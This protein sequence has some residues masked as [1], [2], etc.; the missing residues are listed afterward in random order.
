MWQS[1]PGE[2][3]E[4]SVD[5]T[6]GALTAPE[7]LIDGFWGVVTKSGVCLLAAPKLIKRQVGGKECALFWI[8]A[9]EGGDGGW[10]PVQ[11]LTLPTDTGGKSFYRQKEVAPCRNGTVSS[12]SHLE[13]VHAVV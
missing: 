10:T 2:K 9:T 1:T 8:Q 5:F 4:H 7:R 13:I 12:D 6:E 3:G 11:R